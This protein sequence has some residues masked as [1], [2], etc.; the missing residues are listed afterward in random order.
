[1]QFIEKTDIKYIIYVEGGS[2]NSPKSY[3]LHSGP[4]SRS[5]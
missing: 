5:L 3:T 4:A 2:V 1:M